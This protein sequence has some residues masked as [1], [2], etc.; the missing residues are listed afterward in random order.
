MRSKVTLQ[1]TNS[2]RGESR[3]QRNFRFYQRF[4]RIAFLTHRT[5]PVLS[6]RLYLPL[7]QNSKKSENIPISGFGCNAESSDL[8]LPRP[9]NLPSLGTKGKPSVLLHTREV[10]PNHGDSHSFFRISVTGLFEASNYYESLHTA[11][12]KLAQRTHFEYIR[13]GYSH[14]FQFT[15]NT[16]VPMCHKGPQPPVVQRVLA[17]SSP[18]L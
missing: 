8:N 1:V 11:R 17:Y 16:C 3:A 4:I 13:V 10:W 2:E 6:I 14:I 12:I 18:K 5:F 15:T 7:Q 9:P